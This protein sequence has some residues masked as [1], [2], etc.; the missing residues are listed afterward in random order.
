MN[1]EDVLRKSGRS[2]DGSH[3]GSTF[4]SPKGDFIGGG[5][6][7]DMQVSNATGNKEFG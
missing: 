7:H 2:V 1:I 4:L 5:N 6:I 3:H